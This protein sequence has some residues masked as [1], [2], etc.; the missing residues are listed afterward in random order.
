MNQIIG[1][2]KDRHA[3]VSDRDLVVHRDDAEDGLFTQ[4]ESSDLWVVKD[5]IDSNS[6]KVILL[7]LF[8]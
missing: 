4:F 8:S 2:D 3:S 5:D 6:D 1:L 7:P